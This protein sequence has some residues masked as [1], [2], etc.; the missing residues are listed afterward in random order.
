LENDL[1]RMINKFDSW[2]LHE[3]V[4]VLLNDSHIDRI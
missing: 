1:V 2:L 4:L 3:L